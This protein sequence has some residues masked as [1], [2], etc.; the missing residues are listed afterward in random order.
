MTPASPPV[1]I[2]R[3]T[4]V[5]TWADRSVVENAFE[6]RFGGVFCFIDGKSAAYIFGLFVM[7][8]NNM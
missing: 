7:A 4:A 8:P 3:A 5:C 2:S 1:P 6:P